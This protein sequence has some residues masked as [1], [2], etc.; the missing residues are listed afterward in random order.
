MFVMVPIGVEGAT[1]KRLP[2]VSIGIA[3]AC[4]LAFAATWVIPEDPLG[5]GDAEL[6]AVL[7]YWSEH[8][9]LEVPEAFT[10]QHLNPE[11][12]AAIQAQ[13]EESGAPAEGT[14]AL[15]QAELDGRVR[16]ASSS[17]ESSPLRRRS[18]NW[19]ACRV[20]TG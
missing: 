17:A 20:S 1:V 6:V 16:A 19:K 8:P 10:R 13:R 14:R 2:Y 5:T 3:V 18:T 12:V 9:Y 4:A 15:E 11:L 7:E